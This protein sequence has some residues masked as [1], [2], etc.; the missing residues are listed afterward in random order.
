MPNSTIRLLEH[1]PQQ[2]TDYFMDHRIRRLRFCPMA[3]SCLLTA[4][5]PNNSMTRGQIASSANPAL[6]GD[7]LP[8]Y[9]KPLYQWSHSAAD[10]D[11]RTTRRNSIFRLR[12]R[13]SLLLPGERPRTEW[14]CSGTYG[15][16]PAYL[17]R[18]PEQRS[19][20]CRSV[21]LGIKNED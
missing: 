8:V 11:W 15:S 14:S 1:S 21:I 5:E 2:D 6:A 7:A 10:F 12:S 4:A 17:S 9:D 18:A 13:I 3:W 19:H 20:H 16:G